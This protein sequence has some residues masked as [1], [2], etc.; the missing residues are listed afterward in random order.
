MSVSRIPVLFKFN[1]RLQVVGELN[2]VLAPR[3]VET[4]A[5]SM[6]LEGVIGASD[7]LLYFPTNLILGA[8]KPVQ[9]LQRGSIAYW[10]ICGG[11]CI[12]V[13][14]VAAKQSMSL[15][16]RVV[17]GLEVLKEVR[18]GSSARLSAKAVDP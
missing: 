11:V 5:R 9:R 14:D 4:I 2:R 3:T 17:S 10:P 13:E 6:P 15:I 7:G 16:G 12:S 18:P 1:N 8:E